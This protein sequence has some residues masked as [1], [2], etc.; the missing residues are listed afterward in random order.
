VALE[1]ATIIGA[2]GRIGNLFA[3]LGGGKDLLIGRGDAVPADGSGPIFVCTRNN[4]LQDIVDKCPPS[5][6]GDLVFMQNGYL[7]GFLEANGLAS[8]TQALIFF[9]VAKKGEAPTD[10]KTDLNPEGLTKATGKWA[11]A[12]AARARAAGLACAV[13]PAKAYQVAMFEKLI[14]ISAFMLVGAL[15]GGVTVG[16]VE[17]EHKAEV[18]EL[19]DEMCAA[20]QAAKGVRFGPNCPGRLCAYARSVAHFPTAVKEFDWRNGFFWD[21]SEEAEDEGRPDPLP[22]HTYYCNKGLLDE[23]FNF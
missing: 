12:F 17:R 20:V 15:N 16:G 14:W 19:I 7:D 4:V 6:R 10:G 13:V 9:A 11:D 23:V 8:N 22:K 18:V 5:R 21:L 1:P 3:S 2:S